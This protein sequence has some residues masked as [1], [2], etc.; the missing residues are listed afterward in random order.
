MPGA[1]FA[2]Q[3]WPHC[4]ELFWPADTS[5]KEFRGHATASAILINEDGRI[6]HI[7]HLVLDTW[8]LP[9]G[10]LELSDATL[11]DAA[12]RE[13]AEE[14]GIPGDAV[15][16]ADNAPVHVD[17]HPIPANDAKGEPDHQH[18]DFRYLFR[19]TAGVG[20]LQTEEVTDAAWRDLAS[21]GDPV[22]RER[23]AEALR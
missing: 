17:V 3:F 18:V 14:T 9:G 15:T 19:T 11:L 13:L 2:G 1:V 23:I 4:A 21:V 5:R 16:P 20:D 22:L 8:L 7:H 12:Q 6:L 10:H